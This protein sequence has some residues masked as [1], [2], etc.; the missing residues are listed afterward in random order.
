MNVD[1]KLKSRIFRMIDLLGANEVL[2][3]LQN[4]VTGRS[5][6]NINK[7]NE[8]WSRHEAAISVF[9]RPRLFEFGAGQSLAQNLY[10]S[11][12]C[13]EQVVV[14]LTRMAKVAKVNDAAKQL[15]QICPDFNYH[16]IAT[17][18]DLAREYS[19]K[20]I[21]P[22]DASKTDY[23]DG[24]FDCCVST[25]TLEHIPRSS[26]VSIFTELKRI[27][28]KGGL[29]CASIDYSD[30]YAHTDSS[31]SALNYLSFSDA[32]W[33]KYNHRSHYQ[34]R[35]RHYDYEEIFNELGLVTERN[36][37]FFEDHPLPSRV[38][39]QFNTENNSFRAITGYFVL[40]VV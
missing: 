2:S 5:K 35:L 11:R 31:I 1:W 23:L 18:E 12:C 30:H 21:A 17:F 7:V 9:S 40:R 24:Y 8:N 15:A 22:T 3:F 26:I 37:P 36:E 14:D 29:I 39:A 19:I 27:I 32:E 6:V 25:Y 38:A 16:A 33:E 20:Y 28:K 4:H 13:G 10:L 34:N